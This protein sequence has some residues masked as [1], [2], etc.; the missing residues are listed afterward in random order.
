MMKIHLSFNSWST[1]TALLRLV[2]FSIKDMAL[3]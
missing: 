1:S 2:E 3:F